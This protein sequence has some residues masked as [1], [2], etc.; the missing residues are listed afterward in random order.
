[1]ATTARSGL[2]YTAFDVRAAGGMAVV[3]L[4]VHIIT[5]FVTPY[6]Y[7]RDE[8]L[9][10]AMG[11]HLRV[12][13]MDFPPF[14]AMVAR[15]SH[16]MFGE[17]LPGMR[18]AP[19]LSHAALVASAAWSTWAF[20][21]RRSAQ[22]LAA[23]AV[24]TSPLFMRAGALFQPVTF[25]QLWWTLA[26]VSLMVRIRDDD[27]KHWIGLGIFLGLGALTK[28]SIAFIA[29]G[30]VVAVL[31][32]RLR[33]DLLTPYPWIGLAIAVA[34]GHPS[35]VGQIALGWP[36][37]GQMAALRSTQLARGGALDFLSGQASTGPIVM[38]ALLG[39]VWTLAPRWVD[40][41]R[42]GV[43]SVLEDSRSSSHL[44]AGEAESF[45]WRPIGI[46]TSVAFLLL[47]ALRGKSYYAGP[48]Y[49]VLAAAGAAALDRISHTIAPRRPTKVLA[50]AGA[51]V[52][53]YGLATLPFGLPLLTPDQMVTISEAVAP[54]GANESNTG[55]QL[56]LPQDYADMT[57]WTE[58]V[59]AVAR[60]WHQLPPADTANAVLIATNYGRA[61]A[62]DFLG[63]KL[64]LP[65]VI[66]PAGS[67]WF[68]GPGARRGDVAVIVADD[69]APLRKF[70]A[71]V[72]EMARITNAWGVPEEQTVRVYVCRLPLH[73]LAEV[74]PT[75][76]G[77]N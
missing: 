46:A 43:D 31:A 6:E 19:A 53:V 20:G 76:A 40:P 23:L 10:F 29:V 65:P 18:L 69:A 36:V 2:E 14:I 9:Y 50:L 72:T 26:L 24:A 12:W 33:R 68:F 52:A 73:S 47:L 64:G 42:R 21:G 38:L 49:P 70:Y 37:V 77:Q 28:F 5:N 44:Y 74:W 13:H 17:W 57:G 67:Y 66:S 54:R 51:A 25:D 62:L 59:E 58:M 75:L 61:G 3:V 48:I 71:E 27:P 60:V 63:R 35:I 39:L 41:R 34:I 11:E 22:L 7:H 56:S 32:T 1:V 16:L 15:V 45:D 4:L 55:E 8:F 30:I